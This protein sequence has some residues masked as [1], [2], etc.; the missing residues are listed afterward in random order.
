MAIRDKR[1]GINGCPGGE[2]VLRR[3]FVIGWTRCREK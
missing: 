1:S 2:I 3:S